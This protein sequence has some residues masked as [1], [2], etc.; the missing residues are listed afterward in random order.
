MSG[1]PPTDPNAEQREK[2]PAERRF[3]KYVYGG[4][5][6]GAQALTGI[7]LTY[8]LKYG[9]GQPIFN[10]MAKW[11]GPKLYSGKTVAEA[12]K[13][14]STPLMVTTMIMVGNTFLL[15]VKWLENRKAQIVRSWTEKDCERMEARGT[16]Y[17]K[18]EIEHQ[19]ECLA[20]LD[21]QPPQTW[22]SLLGGRAFGL[23]AV[24]ATVFGMG[25]KRNEAAEAAAAK[26]IAKGFETVG[27]TTIAKSK[28]LENV[29][30][31][32]FLDVFYSMV[33]AGGLY[34]YSHYLN[35]P[36]H[37][38]HNSPSDS[39]FS[40]LGPMPGTPAISALEPEEAQ[41]GTSLKQFTQ[42]IRPS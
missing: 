28:T 32:G 37:H 6:Y 36:K 15:P 29:V 34:V 22:G 27:A 17:T 23:A 16:P 12:T 19:Q 7:G 38:K 26:A 5:S 20:K 10:K 13:E 31:V 4:I 33:S 35:P 2:L 9:S 30:H 24:Y 3:D 21:K 41:H 18:E 25:N 39:P 8:W 42:D 11:L 14:V 1:A 40:L